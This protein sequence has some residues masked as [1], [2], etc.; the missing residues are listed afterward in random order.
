MSTLED[1]DDLAHA[2]LSSGKRNL[3]TIGAKSTMYVTDA[4]VAFVQDKVTSANERVVG[5]IRYPWVDAIIWRPRQG[6]FKLP[7]LQIWM[8]EDFPVKHLGSWDHYID[9]NSTTP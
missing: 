8:H 1:N 5:H 2:V 6:R 7:K 3:R 9:L 4:R